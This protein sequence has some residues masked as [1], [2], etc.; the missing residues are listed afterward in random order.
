MPSRPPRAG[1]TSKRKHRDDRPSAD[2]RGY[3][4]EWR[5]ARKR[6]LAAHPL[7]EQCRSEGRIVP[8][9]VVDHIEP[10]RG[11]RRL[12]WDR[13][14]WRSLCKRCHDVKTATQDGGFGRA[15]R[16]GR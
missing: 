14:N 16:K 8:A 13:N 9:T 1:A 6:F 4:W 15:P 7:C 5:K 3:T 10:H 12:M 11:D 2:S